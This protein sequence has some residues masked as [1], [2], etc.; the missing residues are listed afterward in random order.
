MNAPATF[1]SFLLLE[2]EK[3]IIVEK[4]L[5]VSNAVVF[6]ISKEDHTLAN[7]LRAQLLKDPQVIFAGYK[8]PHPLEHKV[9]LRVQTINSDYTPVQAMEN[10]IKDLIF[11]MDML[12]DR[13]KVAIANRQSAE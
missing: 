11:E 13:V 9:V 12:E 6:T 1:E 10:A 3:K 8:I 7:M 4:D 5:K 2:G